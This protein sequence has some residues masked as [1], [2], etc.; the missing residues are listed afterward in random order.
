MK[1]DF[2][3][4]FVEV[5]CPDSRHMPDI[6]SVRLQLLGESPDNPQLDGWVHT[7]IHSE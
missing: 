1:L 2:P 3:L 6:L 4:S 7:G 5:L